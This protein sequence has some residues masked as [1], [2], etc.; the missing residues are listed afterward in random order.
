MDISVIIINYNTPQLTEACI[1]SVITK[2]KG[3]TYEIILVD[4]HSDNFNIVAF[5]NQFPQ[6]KIILSDKNLGFAGGNNLGIYKA[7][8]KYILLLNSDTVLQNDAITIAFNYLEK[9][10]ATGVVSSHL[11]FPDGTHQ[12]TCQRLPSIRFQL[13]EVLRLQKLVSKKRAGEILLGPFFDH[14][15]E[16][17]PDWVWGTFFMFRS[18]LLTLMKDHKLDETFFMYCEDMQWCLDIGRLG[19]KIGYEPNARVLHYM[20]GSSGK[21]ILFMKNNNE[22]FLSRNYNL[23]H[24]SIIKILSFLLKITQ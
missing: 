19:Y 14:K 21:S 7:T 24:R 20:G 9:N 17:N 23:V 12:P 22:L 11:E 2:T 15:S 10:T 18:K 4:N 8:G 16:V 5:E 13:F 6:L 3:V 1:S